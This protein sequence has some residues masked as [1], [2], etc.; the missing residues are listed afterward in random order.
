MVHSTAGLT[1]WPLYQS[2]ERALRRLIANQLTKEP[3]LVELFLA[4]AEGASAAARLLLSR[5]MTGS[6]MPGHG[7]NQHSVPHVTFLIAVPK[8]VIRGEA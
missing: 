8:S 7:V 6:G 3:P 4:I 1:C 2:L 5:V